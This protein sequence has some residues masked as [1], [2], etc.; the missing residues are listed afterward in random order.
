M[1][2]FLK[3]LFGRMFIVG[4]LIFAQ[5][6]L[7]LL[8]IWK[9]SNYFVYFYAFSLL[10]SMIAMLYIIGRRDNPSY[11]LAWVIPILL[12]PM[13]GGL[14]YIFFG[15]KSLP[16][17]TRIRAEKNDAKRQRAL[18]VCSDLTNHMQ[19]DAAAIS[20]YIQNTSAYPA[21]HN[22][23][24]TYFPLGED[25]FAQLKISLRAAKHYIFLEYFIIEQ[26]VM[27]DSILAILQEKV[28]QG[29]DVRILY[30]DIG[31]LQ[32]LPYK[33][34]AKLRSMG[35]R[36]H[37]FN[38]FHPYLSVR[39]NN[40]D[41][42]KIAVIDGHTAF[43]GGINLA[44]EY[45]NVKKP[46]GHWKD[47]AVMLCG[48]AAWSLTLMF[49]E[50]WSFYDRSNDDFSLYR[51]SLYAPR[52]FQ[53]D[54]YVQP[55]G[56]T[57]LDEEQLSENV[58]LQLIS[59]ATRYIYITTPY[60]IVDNE[61]LTALCNAAK[62]GIDVRI[63]TPYICDH[64]Y[65]HVISQSYYAQL[66]E[67][68][69]KVYE[70]TPGFIHAKSFVADDMMATVGTI[71][72]DY[73]SLYLH[74]ECGVF[75]YNCTSIAEIRDDFLQTLVKSQQITLEDCRNVRLRTRIIRAFLRI[76]APLM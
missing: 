76:F 44:D 35:I 2:K 18:S 47:T 60:F 62:S 19:P 6:V 66:I 16:K 70:Y 74:Y 22:T 1:H 75:L 24:C 69:V 21:Y 65:V 13:F 63:I 50:S 40:R 5:F 14:C 41:H 39:M 48:D 49:L 8:L 27:W 30:D 25:L 23:E 33:Y 3:F 34:D 20:R 26:G 4:L 38:E 12:F 36:C 57:P 59:R 7:L 32:L 55:Y 58:Y 56:D 37:V 43:T 11:K 73:R 72:L 68:G 15:H 42:R 31:C 28:A 67:S 51:P 9:I 45:I 17:R 46:H 61:M 54:G 29:V 53:S 10:L 71:N 64:W 52:T